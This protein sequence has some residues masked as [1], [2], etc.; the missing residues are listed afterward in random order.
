MYLRKLIDKGVRI[1]HPPSVYVGQEVPVD[2]IS[3][4]DVE[5][6]PGCRITGEK[7]VIS[8]G[9]C[10]GREGP[11]TLEDCQ[12][13]PRVSLGGG[14]FRQSVFLDGVVMG[15]GAHV[16]EGCLLEEEA[17][18]AHCVGLKQTILMPFVTL[19]SLI[20]LCD[21]LMAGGTSR[22][23]HSEVGSSYIHFNFTPDGDKT[24]PSLIGDVPRGVMLRQRPIFLGGQGGIVGPVRIAFG[25]VTAAGTVVTRDITEENRLVFPKVSPGSDRE[26]IRGG[27]EDIRRMVRLNILYLANL[28]ALEEWYRHVRQ[29]FCL[30]GEFGAALYNGVMEKLNMGKKERLRR[31]E[32][33]AAKIAISLG[34]SAGG[35]VTE[36]KR[37]FC[38][39][40]AYLEEMFA[41]FR[42]DET[43]A[44]LREKFIRAFFTMP[45]LVAGDYL[46]SIK[47]MPEELAGLGTRWLERVVG[48]LFDAAARK[49]PAL[50][51]FG[52]E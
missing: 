17:G 51:L 4:R 27:Y 40:V 33:T 48:A 49:M 11:V 42:E 19:G 16:R 20:N 12:I 15:A 38:T 8:A 28:V 35:A 34:F 39:V 31:L 26:F 44:E 9:V 50:E 46:A 43:T 7:T 30:R 41:T 36:G 5:I 45:Q 32:E 6:Y 29:P 10:L 25:T 14:Y 3:G 23:D 52:E 37:Q 18:G 22:K 1:L 24:T 2:H 13:G 47:A 21:C